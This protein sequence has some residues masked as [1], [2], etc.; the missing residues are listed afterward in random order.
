[1]FFSNKQSLIVVNA[2][3][4]PFYAKKHN[5]KIL[6]QTQLREIFSTDK[7]ND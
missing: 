1:M 2:N 5:G 4:N 3:K 6:G 7:E